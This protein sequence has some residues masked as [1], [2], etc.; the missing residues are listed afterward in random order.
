MPSDILDRL[1]MLKPDGGSFRVTN[2]GHVVTLIL[3]DKNR[4]SKYA[5]EFDAMS[6]LQQTLVYM[7]MREFMPDKGSALKDIMMNML[8]VYVGQLPENF[9][10][11]KFTEPPSYVEQLDAGARTAILE[12]LRKPSNA[13]KSTSTD[14]LGEAMHNSPD[15]ADEADEDDG[16]NE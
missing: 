14:R 10:P 4:F 13:K 12:F 9:L 1:K 6:N 15:M 16:V 3:A 7:Y 2:S 8:P 5:D 11:I